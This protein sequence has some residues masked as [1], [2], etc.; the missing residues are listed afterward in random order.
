MKK[1]EECKKKQ[2]KK[3]KRLI[4]KDLRVYGLWNAAVLKVLEIFE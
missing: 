3:I 2:C 1:C 4:Q